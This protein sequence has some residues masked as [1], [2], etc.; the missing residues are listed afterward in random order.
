VRIR[1]ALPA[2]AAAVR[3]LVRSAYAHYVPL[4]GR[5]PAP[6]VDD[7]AAR[8]AAGQVWVLEQDGQLIGTALLQ[9]DA[10][11][12]LLDNLAV[13]PARQGEGHGRALIACIEDAARRRG[14]AV[15]KLYTNVK[16]TANIAL[17]SRLGYVETARYVGNGFERVDMEKRLQGC[18]GR[19]GS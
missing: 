8:I 5:E 10:A 4:I 17:Y 11:G 13:D 7:H 2:D 12:A 18:S 14:H 15:L 3:T 1:Q 19:P 9:E 16:M 6:M